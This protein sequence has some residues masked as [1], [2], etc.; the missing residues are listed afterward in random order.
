MKDLKE[1]FVEPYIFKGETARKARS[2]IDQTID[3]ASETKIFNTVIELLMFAAIY[4]CYLNIKEEPFINNKQGDTLTIFQETISNYRDELIYIYKSIML[5]SYQN[6]PE[7]AIDRAFRTYRN[8]ENKKIF[9]EYVHGGI[10]ELY[11]K[12]FNSTEA[13]YESYLN[14]VKEIIND[15]QVFD[16]DKPINFDESILKDIES[17]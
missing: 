17:W 14:V 6:E 4:G 13:K 12:F 5:Y 3:G 2:L 10:S 1:L 11:D 16:E 8:P 7:K 15:L 9:D